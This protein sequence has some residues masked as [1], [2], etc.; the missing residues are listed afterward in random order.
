MF[1][2]LAPHLLTS[3]RNRSYPLLILMNV[4]PVSLRVKSATTT[5]VYF[6]FTGS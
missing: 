6:R 4:S 5:G 3:T 1:V 2:E